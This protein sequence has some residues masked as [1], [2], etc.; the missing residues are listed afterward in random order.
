M[1][2][3]CLSMCGAAVIKQ[4]EVCRDYVSPGAL[5]ISLGCIWPLQ[6]LYQ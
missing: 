4:A 2:S 5:R 6:S 1:Q 3:V